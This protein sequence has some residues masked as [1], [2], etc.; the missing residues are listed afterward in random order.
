[1]IDFWLNSEAS[2]EGGGP[3]LRIHSSQVRCLY[4]EAS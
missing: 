3:P 1:M 4:P 2:R